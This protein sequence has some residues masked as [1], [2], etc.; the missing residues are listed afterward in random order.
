MKAII[1]FFSQS[2]NTRKIALSIYGGVK[3]LINS[4]RLVSMSRVHPEELKNYDLIGIGS[5]VWGGVPANVRRFINR[6]PDLSGRYAFSFCAHGA[7]PERFFPQMV[8]LLIRKGLTV[9]ATKDWY[10]SVFHPLL[11]KPYLTDGHPDE[12][13]LEEARQFGREV[14]KVFLQISEGEKVSLPP[15]PPLPPPRIVKRIYPRLSLV[16]EKCKY[17]SCKLCMDHCRL[18]VID[19]SRDPPRFPKICQPCYFCEMICPEGAIVI[20]Y[21][22]DSKVEIERA[23]TIFVKSLEEAEKEGRFRRLVPIEEVGWET[24]FYKVFNTHPRVIPEED[25]DIG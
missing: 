15:V 9:I 11:P 20:D 4:C 13:D 17:P 14:A 5:P 1:V 8:R 25:I 23:K 19:L 12:I 10:G 3:G 2:G 21:E 18:K 22:E 16:R 24:P 7:K 6:A